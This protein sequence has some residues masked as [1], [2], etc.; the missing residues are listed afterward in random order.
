LIG[1]DGDG[2]GSPAL[3]TRTRRKCLQRLSVAI[4]GDNPNLRSEETERHCLAYAT[5]RTGYDGHSLGSVLLWF[6]A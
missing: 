5:G 6:P 2:V 3:L 4:N 1:L